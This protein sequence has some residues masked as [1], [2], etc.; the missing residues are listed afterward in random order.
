MRP[1]KI[2]WSKINRNCVLKGRC[3]HLCKED[4]PYENDELNMELKDLKPPEF[5]SLGTA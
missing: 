1:L 2:P 3:A 4:S 5:H